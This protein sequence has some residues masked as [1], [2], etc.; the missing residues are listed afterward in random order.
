M[1][2][3]MKIKTNN[4]GIPP[5]KLYLAFVFLLDQLTYATTQP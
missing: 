4:K 3:Y 5:Y 1:S 2:R